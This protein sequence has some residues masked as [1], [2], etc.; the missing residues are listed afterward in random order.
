MNNKLEA[1]RLINRRT[2][3]GSFVGSPAVNQ[4]VEVID[5]SHTLLLQELKAARERLFGHHELNE[6]I[7]SS[8]G[9]TASIPNIPDYAGLTGEEFTLAS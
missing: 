6:D 3:V 9:A 8:V 5:N 4:E 1:A 2:T 7:A